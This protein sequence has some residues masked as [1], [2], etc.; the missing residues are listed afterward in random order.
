MK[1]RSI[2]MLLIA[3]CATSASAADIKAGDSL[4]TLSNLRHEKNEIHSINYQLPG[5][6]P[7]CSDVTVKK[8]RTGKYT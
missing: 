3:A 5:R 7:V 8:I 2:G 4:Q 6:I 1:R